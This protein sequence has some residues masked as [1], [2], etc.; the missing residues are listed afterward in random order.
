MKVHADSVIAQS[1]GAKIRQTGIRLQFCGRVKVAVREHVRLDEI[2]IEA[3][4]GIVGL[5]ER[6]YSGFRPSI[7]V[8]QLGFRTP[9]EARWVLLTIGTG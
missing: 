5:R 1:A 4:E 6:S 9:T 3:Q 2:G 8:A 7:A